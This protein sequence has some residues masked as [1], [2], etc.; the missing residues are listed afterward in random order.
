M[1]KKQKILITV[2]IVLTLFVSF[3]CGQAYAKYI[4]KVRGNGGVEI[5]KWSF[6]VNGEQTQMKNINLMQTCKE[7]T[8]ANGKIA[9]GTSGYFDII[10]DASEAEV[11]ME[12]EVKFENEQNKPTN[13]IFTYENHE[14]NSIKELENILRGQINANDAEKIKSLTIDWKWEYETKDNGKTI[15]Q[16]DEIDTQNGLT[17]SNYTFDIVVTGTQMMPTK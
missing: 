1:S 8:L 5:A 10:I 6:K 3:I 9:P 15:Q 2:L 14:C 17:L 13:L 12:Y 11:G 16:N 4:T 7:E